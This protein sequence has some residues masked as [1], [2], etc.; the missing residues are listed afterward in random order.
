MRQKVLHGRPL[1]EDSDEE[2]DQEDQDESWG[3]KKVYWSGDTAD[4]EIGQEMED[5]E[6]EEKA[7]KVPESSCQSVSRF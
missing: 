4:L 5:A 1:D 3:K 2:E 6:D 7:A